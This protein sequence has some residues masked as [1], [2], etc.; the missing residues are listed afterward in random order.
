MN[1]VIETSPS[2][3]LFEVFEEF[4]QSAVYTIDAYRNRGVLS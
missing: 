4:E 2:S 3:F 1:S